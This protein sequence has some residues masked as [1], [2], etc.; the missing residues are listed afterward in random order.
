MNVPRQQGFTV[1]EFVAAVAALLALSVLVMAGLQG[2]GTQA[3]LD[4]T[5]A[6]MASIVEAAEAYRTSIDPATGDYYDIPPGS[7]VTILEDHFDGQGFPE[8][9]IWGEPYTIRGG[10]TPAVVTTLVPLD[11]VSP[12]YAAA[13]DDDDGTILEMQAVDIVRLPLSRRA[14]EMKQ[15]VYGEEVR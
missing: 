12:L 10:D 13:T 5:L 1:L 2:E 14:R 4:R 15:Q 7:D 9:N 3:R 11:G 8:E 6:E